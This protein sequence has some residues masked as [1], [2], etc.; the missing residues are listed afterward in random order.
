MRKSFLRFTAITRANETPSLLQLIDSLDFEIDK[1][2]KLKE[3]N[4]N[5]VVLVKTDTGQFVIKRYNMKTISHRVSRLFRRTRASRSWE[6]GHVLKS[7]SIRTPSPIALIEERF[8]FLRGKAYLITKYS[9]GYP[10]QRLI[11]KKEFGK[12]ALWIANLL[13]TI[14]DNQLIHG[15]LKAQNLLIENDG[16]CIIDLDSN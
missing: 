4:T 5:T 3:G 10:A 8:G 11:E 2:I 1:G 9:S 13:Q 7:L 15:D 6:N 12:E 14:F 16:A